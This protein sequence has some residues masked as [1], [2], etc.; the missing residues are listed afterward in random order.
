MRDLM[1]KVTLTLLT[2]LTLLVLQQMEFGAR[3]FISK[4][5][6]TNLSLSLFLTK[7][8]HDLEKGL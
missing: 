3:K 7:I 8:T 6:L 1:I 2:L 4:H 5:I